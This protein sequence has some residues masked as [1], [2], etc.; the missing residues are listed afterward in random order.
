MKQ[1]ARGMCV[2]GCGY[3]VERVPALLPLEFVQR[4]LGVLLGQAHAAIEAHPHH[5]LR[6]HKVLLVPANLPHP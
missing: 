3:L 1:A 6:V 5:H 2:M 4:G